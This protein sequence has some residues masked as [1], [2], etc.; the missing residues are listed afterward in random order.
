MQLSRRRQVLVA[1]LALVPALGIVS[2]PLGAHAGDLAG[3]LT[4][5]VAAAD[6]EAPQPHVRV[7]AVDGGGVEVASAEQHGD[8]FD[9]AV[10][11]GRYRLAVRDL[12]SEQQSVASTWY[13]SAV[14]MR[15]AGTVTVAAGDHIAVTGFRSIRPGRIAGSYRFPPGGFNRGMTGYVAAWRLDDRG[16]APVLENGTAID[17]TSS[18]WRISL[19][20]PGRYVLRLSTQHGLWASSYW[21]DH[22]TVT[23]QSAATPVTVSSGQ[24]TEE[25]TFNLSLPH[26]DVTR[27]SGSDRYEVSAAVASRVPGIRGTVYVASGANF[28]DALSAGPAAAHDQAPLLLV[29]PSGVPSSVARELSRR[30]PEHIVVVGGS[31]PTTVVAQLRSFSPDVQV[32]GGR[33][34][35]AVGRSLIERTWATSGADEAY[36]ATGTGFPDALSAGAAAASDGVPLL[37]VDGKR[38]SDQAGTALRQKLDVRSVTAV[39]GPVSL[40]QPIVAAVA[41][42]AF[43]RR[44]DGRDRY[45]VSANVGWGA[46]GYT[47]YS[48]TIYLTVGT[49]FPDALSG[50]PL[51]GPQH[52]P[53]LVVHPDCI[54][55][56]VEA[57]IAAVA[58][59]HVVLLGGPAS[60]GSG[61]ASLSACR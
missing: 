8:G 38:S 47:G 3:H 46:F 43:D 4:G 54:P 9:L 55:E 26:R 2:F 15:D 7:S 16:G 35:Y 59:E 49:K 53:L 58:P 50:T 40:S 20:P 24:T 42:D 60:L 29:S 41:G 52:A 14:S 17:A 44:F 22:G 27:I 33:D 12:D 25:H 23:D 11:A 32:V 21:S 28:P 61:V 13:P 48:N 19:L 57:Y 18:S 1:A 30:Q 5:T 36:L 31:V 56:E 34:R 51:A 45:A 37:L 39:G 10:P 6:S